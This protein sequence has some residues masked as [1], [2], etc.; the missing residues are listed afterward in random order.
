MKNKINVST[1]VLAIA[2][3]FSL[4]LGWAA[5]ITIINAGFE[6]PVLAEG[7]DGTTTTW[8]YGGYDVTE[9][10]VWIGA[11]D[12]ADIYNTSADYYRS[13]LAAEGEN[14]AWILGLAGYDSGI[15]QILS[16]TLLANAKYVL[17][18]KIG[19]PL[20]WNSGLAPNY[21]IELLAGGLLLASSTGL[22]PVDDTA[23]LTASLTFNSGVAPP[24]LGQPLE[25]RLLAL[26]DIRDDGYELDY[27][28]VKLTVTT[29]SPS[30]LVLKIATT[31]A[32][33]GFQ[34]NSQSTKLYDLV[35]HTELTTS[36]STWLPYNDGVTTYA[37]IPATG[38]GTN[39]L[40]NVLKIGPKR[41]FALVEKPVSP[42]PAN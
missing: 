41:F 4:A 35:S 23:F 36:P 17:S 38:T 30:P 29:E 16:A 18:V 42:P 6:N 7:A 21:R 1:I 8:Q 22:A 24:Q 5:P 34:W 25:I 37:N 13:G 20:G 40:N 19:N 11:F 3:Y 12:D 31:G 27:D 10:G 9:P 32:N 39:T 15:R 26:E 14:M 33:L 2:A 28:D